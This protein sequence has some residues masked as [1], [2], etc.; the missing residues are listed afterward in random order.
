[1]RRGLDLFVSL[2]G[3]GGWG[4]A[5]YFFGSRLVSPAAGAL[6][7]MA[8]VAAFLAASF[9]TYGQ[10]AQTR[11]TGATASSLQRGL[12]VFISLAGA[13]AWGLVGLFLGSRFVSDAAGG[14]LALALVT[15]FGAVMLGNYL[16][17]ARLDR[18]AAGDCPRCR[19]K[20]RSDHRHRRWDAS[21]S[22]WLP[23]VTSWDC[24]GCGYN[25]SETWPCP[26]CP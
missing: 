9:T 13:A 10:E 12:D 7:A 1:M 22:E 3:A 21:R 8:L 24:A 2:A 18:L 5:A 4:L 6:L 19:A 20:V 17:E 15:S 14:V 26:S 25:H 11:Q 16:Q 23:P